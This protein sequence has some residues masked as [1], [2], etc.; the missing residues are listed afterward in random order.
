MVLFQFSFIVLQVQYRSVQVATL[1]VPERS[2]HFGKILTPN[3]AMSRFVQMKV[4]EMGKNRFESTW[5]CPSISF[6]TCTSIA[7]NSTFVQ[8][9]FIL[10]IIYL[11]YYSGRLRRVELFKKW[12]HAGNSHHRIS[13]MR[14]PLCDK[15]SCYITYRDE[16]S[17]VYVTEEIFTLLTINNLNVVETGGVIDFSLLLGNHVDSYLYGLLSVTNLWY[18]GT[19]TKLVLF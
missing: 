9:E 18:R 10:E 6:L 11:R 13:S 8:M 7:G 15:D 17:N 16:T 19:L 12:Y 4:N 3:Q 14:L 1:V 5:L 2:L